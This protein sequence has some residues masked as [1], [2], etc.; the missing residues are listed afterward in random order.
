MTQHYDPEG[1]ARPEVGADQQA[2]SSFS[3]T[4]LD[5]ATLA[6]GATRHSADSELKRKLL[7]AGLLREDAR[8]GYL[9]LTD[10]AYTL[11]EQNGYVFEPKLGWRL[12]TA[13]AARAMRLP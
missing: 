4:K 2:G 11:L 6:A 10:K 12:D 5:I 13:R 8:T 1:D 3:L 9:D 7:R